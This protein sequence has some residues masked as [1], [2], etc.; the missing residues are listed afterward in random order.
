MSDNPEIPTPPQ[1]NNAAPDSAPKPAMEHTTPPAVN[2]VNPPSKIPD[3]PVP[4]PDLPADEPKP[5]PAPPVPT[6]RAP[7]KPS[8]GVN[9]A[10]FATVII[11]IVI[12]ALIVYAYLKSK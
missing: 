1:D 12:A 7:K 9:S 4:A 3:K 5:T 6:P 8:N 10:I 11:V 2:D